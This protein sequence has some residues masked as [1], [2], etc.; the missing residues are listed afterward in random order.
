MLFYISIAIIF[1]ALISVLYNYRENQS[2]L[3]LSLILVIFSTYSLT[4]YYTVYGKDPILLAFFYGHFSP[5][6][7]L[8]GPLIFWYS[9]SIVEKDRFKIGG[10]QFFHLIPF[11]IHIV[12]IFPY[13]FLPFSV[14]LDIAKKVVGNINE[15]HR[16]DIVNRF[17]SQDVAFFTRP[18]LLFIYSLF[19]LIFVYQR[20]KLQ[21]NEHSK[22]AIYFLAS[23]V[24]LSINFGFLTYITYSSKNLQE[25]VTNSPFNILSGIGYLS[26]PIII[27]TLFPEIIYGKT[28]FKV[29]KKVLPKTENYGLFIDEYKIIADKFY[30]F[31]SQMPYLNPDFNLRDVETRLGYTEDQ[32]KECLKYNFNKKFTE[33]RA[34]YRVNYAKKLLEDGASRNTSID[35]IG[36]LSGFSNRAN[37][38]STFKNY[39]GQTPSEYLKSLQ[40]VS[41]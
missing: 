41:C 2:S 10:K 27:F 7:Y 21:R 15:F 16:F 5:L 34:E 23:M 1:I 12:S 3:Y 13:Y 39:T 30:D 8:L 26:V 36:A 40:E 38:Y 20:N 37:F 9:K 33:I 11:T 25:A 6:W 4:H 17:Y 18:A 22:W 14:K 32:L 19:S 35:G 28:H 24:L 31:M 29:Q